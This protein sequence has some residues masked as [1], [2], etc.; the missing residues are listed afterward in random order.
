MPLKVSPH[1]EERP[2]VAS[3]RTH[4]AT[5]AILTPSP[6]LVLFREAARRDAAGAGARAFPGRELRL[7]AGALAAL[8]AEALAEIDEA[9]VGE[10]AIV[11]ALHQ[12][13]AAFAHLGQLA[14]GE[15]EQLVI[16]ADDRDG[17]AF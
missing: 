10:A 15:Q 16:V 2:E 17:V 1:P 4:D 3:R 13:A 11:I 7:G 12:D 6:E 9:R 14:R 5:A 8:P